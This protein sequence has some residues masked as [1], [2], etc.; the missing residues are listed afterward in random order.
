MIKNIGDNYRI[1]DLIIVKTT[2][3]SL[4]LDYGLLN[5]TFETPNHVFQ[6]DEG[7]W[8]KLVDRTDVAQYITR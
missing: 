1:Y 6:L 2:K 5:A 8:L 7:P 4:V 3:K